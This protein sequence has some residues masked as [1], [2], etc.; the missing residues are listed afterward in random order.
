MWYIR[1]ALSVGS[2]FLLL[3]S[4][5]TLLIIPAAAGA[6]DRVDV[7]I[8]FR[9]ASDVGAVH[10]VGGAVARSYKTFPVIAAS[11]PAN[12][13]ARLQANPN[14]AFVEANQQRSF[15][16]PPPNSPGKGGGGGGSTQPP[17]T[18]P[19]GVDRIEADVAAANGYTGAGVGL[20]VLDTGIDRNHP[21]LVGN[22]KGGYSA[23]NKN[24]DNFEDKNGHGTHVSGTAAAVD[25]TIGV[26]GVGTSINLYM[27]Q[28]S[29]GSILLLSDILEGIDWVNQNVASKN[30]K[31][32]NMS[33][34]GG[35]SQAED[36]ALQ[37][38]Y[39]L[40]ILP[41]A[42]A[43]NDGCDCISY[44]A[45]LPQVLAV[46]ATR[47]DDTLASFSNFGSDIELAAPG[48]SILST[49][50]GDGYATLNGTSM[51]SP[52]VAGTAAVAFAAHPGYTNDQIRDL[53]HRTAEDLGAAGKDNS[54]GY[55]L[56]RADRAA[57]TP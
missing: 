23:V 17:E 19:W 33:F 21:D 56:V 13:L 12:A 18:L 54:F 7:L 26:I 30:I 9:G 4:L 14:V 24:P 29:N 38:S 16:A 32:M 34:G 41:V 25:N 44:P 49:Y 35:Y 52:H 45:A 5:V 8:G 31:A 22:L 40:G 57:T 1:K 27:V 55:G 10:A 28:I 37:K 15:F 36:L 51:A 6:N 39:S 47:S 42:A 20:A 48:V 46:S 53:L 43:G 11:V 2:V 50:K 3:A